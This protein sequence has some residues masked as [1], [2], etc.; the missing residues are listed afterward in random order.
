MTITRFGLLVAAGCIVALAEPPLPELKVE[1]KPGGSVL[2]IHNKATQPLTAFLIEL[3]DYPGSSYA[4]WQD[5]IIKGEPVGP[6]GEEKIEITNMTVGAVPE[7][8]KMRAA[9]Y[10]DGT[11][12]GIPEKVAQLV[13]RR[14]SQLKV[15]RDLSAMLESETSKGAS[16]A[17]ISKD[18]EQWIESTAPKGK[19]DR[20]SQ[21]A[22]DQAAKQMLV[23][24]FKSELGAQPLA[25][26]LAHVHALE[27]QLAYS[28]PAL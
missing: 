22:I 1:P 17:E 4:L 23:T 15:C 25:S 9:I 8:V 20:N 2:F 18:L 3:V 12:S 19:V 24:H 21:A 27:Q 26:V 5:E 28:R 11:S 14:R 10:S 6:G 13:A 7:Y 16:T